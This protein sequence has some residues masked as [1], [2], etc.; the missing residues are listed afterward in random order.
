MMLRYLLVIPTLALVA[1]ASAQTS[2]SEPLRSGLDIQVRRSG[3]TTWTA[4]RTGSIVG[5]GRSC[6]MVQ[7]A[8]ADPATGDFI[9]TSFKAFTGVR[10]R[11]VEGRWHEISGNE[12]A[13]LRGCGPGEPAASLPV[14][15][16]TT[17]GRRPR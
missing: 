4:A 13:V 15:S 10:L 6:V 3:D 8:P 7:I 14:A 1:P 2:T 12:L 11:D 16:P 5:R 9:L 17:T